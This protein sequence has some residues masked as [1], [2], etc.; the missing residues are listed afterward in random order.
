MMKFVGFQLLT[1]TAIK[2]SKANKSDAGFD[3]YADE[4]TVIKSRDR[5]TIKTGIA[6]EMQEELAGLVWPRSGLSVKQ[7]IDVL[8]GVIDSGYRGEIMVCLYNTSN[9]DVQINRGDR[10]A[11][12]IFQEVPNISLQLRQSLGSSQ[13]GGN[14]FGSTGK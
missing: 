3:L 12:I 11:Q 4:N 2:P 13:R 8:A 10:I 1:D 14:G 6:L 9:E 7:G 5:T